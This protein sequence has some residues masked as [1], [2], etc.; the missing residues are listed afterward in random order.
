VQLTWIVQVL[1]EPLIDQ[2][3]QD[4][5]FRKLVLTENITK[6]EN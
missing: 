5:G 2:D 3:G 4:Q 6:N 1:V